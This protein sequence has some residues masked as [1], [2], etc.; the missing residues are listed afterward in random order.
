MVA[1]SFKGM[2]RTAIRI[3]LGLEA[4]DPEPGARRAKRHTIRAR[5][6][7]R[8][9]RPGDLLQLY[10]GMRTKQCELIGLAR[11]EY[12]DEVTLHFIAPG[13]GRVEIGPLVRYVTPKELDAFA[14]SDGFADWQCLRDFWRDNHPDEFRAGK[15]LQGV[16]IG[17]RP[18]TAAEAL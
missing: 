6:K 2:F 1:Y 10:R 11:C 16:I 12:A 4:E 5:G 13:G 17:W 3:G 14:R 15:F 18:L 7:R 8:H 9:A